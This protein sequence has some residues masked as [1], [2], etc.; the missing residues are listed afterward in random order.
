MTTIRRISLIIALLTIVLTPSYAAPD[1]LAGLD[2]YITKSMKDWKIPGL[3]IAVVKDDKIVY[4]KGFGTRE[5]G[6]DEPVDENTVFAIGSTTKAFT[7]TSIAMLVYDKKLKW[8]DPVVQHMPGFQMYDPWV[9]REMRVNDLLCNRSGLGA[10]S[11]YLWYATDLT[12]DQIISRL[13]YIKPESSFRYNY[14]YRNAMF[15][16]GGQLI[17]TVTG[18]SWDDFIKTRIFTPLGMTRSY[19]TVRELKGLGNVSS[20]HTDI[21]GKVTAIPFRN[22]DNMAPAGAIDSSIRDMAQWVRLHLSGGVYNGKQVVGK[23]EIEETHKQY[24]PI[25]TNEDLKLQFPSTNRVDYCLGWV[26]MDHYGH[27]LVWH[28]GSIDGNLAFVGLV[29]EQHLGVVIL[30]N[31]DQHMLHQALFLEVI[32]R[33]LSLPDPDWSAKYLTLWNQHQTKTAKAT[34]DLLGA[35]VPNT[36]PTLPLQSYVGTYQNEAYGPVKITLAGDHLILRASSY[37]IADLQHFNYDT[38]QANWRDPVIATRMDVPTLITFS[39]DSIGKV[40]NMKVFDMEF[41]KA[42]EIKSP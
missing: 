10:Q 26:T 5:V 33:Y 42:G 17:P 9:T 13:R 2:S 4:I 27:L 25:Y 30:T 16:T 28:N 37:L 15:L 39:I 24:T 7:T 14:A 36:H 35:K 1:P 31:Y 19:T 34:K 38:F 18:A 29:P 23:A 32:G 21:N 3:A 40:S 22:I 8:T 12:R 11:E 41:E 20:P 6:K